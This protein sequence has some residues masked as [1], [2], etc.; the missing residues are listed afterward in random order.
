MTDAA[1]LP[2]PAD[3]VTVRP[4]GPGEFEAWAPLWQGYLDFYRASVPEWTTRLTF[5]R[6]TGGPPEPMGGFLAWRGEEA[7]GMVNWVDHRSCWTSGDYCYLQDLFV[8][9]ARRA[10]GVGRALIAAVNHAARVRGCSRVYW[11]T[12]ET[13]TDAMTLYDQVADRSGFIQYRQL[14]T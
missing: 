10:R 12:H 6:L 8:N 11:L 5:A 7:I 1:A 9:P 4:L 13:N 14:L 2:D 3:A